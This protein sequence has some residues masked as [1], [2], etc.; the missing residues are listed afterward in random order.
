MLLARH[1]RIGWIKPSLSVS[2][3]TATNIR[4]ISDDRRA[5]ILSKHPELSDQTARKR[6]SEEY[7]DRCA[8]LG[9]RPDTNLQKVRLPAVQLEQFVRLKSEAMAA[10]LLGSEPSEKLSQQYRECKQWLKNNTPKPEDLYEAERTAVLKQFPNLT[11]AAMRDN[12]LRQYEIENK[13]ILVPRNE[14]ETADQPRE[15]V[16]GTTH[17]EKTRYCNLALQYVVIHLIDNPVASKYALDEWKADF[18]RC[19]RRRAMDDSEQL[20]VQFVKALDQ[21]VQIGSA[22]SPPK[23]FEKFLQS[24]LKALAAEVFLPDSDSAE[25]KKRRHELRAVILADL[26]VT[27]THMKQRKGG[28]WIIPNPLAV[29][30]WIGA[31]F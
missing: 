17:E 5:T 31:I 6:K 3:T 24:R 11:M 27:Q 21:G 8:K 25:R 13:K 26:D 4:R 30:E 20:R 22:Q 9:L 12:I 16:A 29:F 15:F 10:R 7:I 2:W 18:K 19:L 23:Q 14:Q 28:W 1:N